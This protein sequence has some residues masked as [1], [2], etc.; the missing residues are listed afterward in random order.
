MHGQMGWQRRSG[1]N[2]RSPIETAMFHY[3]TIISRRLHARTLSNQKTETKIKRTV[4]KRMERFG[5]QASARV[6]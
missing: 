1:Y 6:Q 2:R 3:K 4:L 5:M